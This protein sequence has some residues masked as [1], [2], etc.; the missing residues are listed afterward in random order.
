VRPGIVRPGVVKPGLVRPRRRRL[1]PGAAG[2][3]AAVAVLLAGVAA[4]AVALVAAPV[5]RDAAAEE[6]RRE[7][8][9]GIYHLDDP[10]L[11]ERVFDRVVDWLDRVVSRL[12]EQAPGG[13]VGLL[14]MVAAAVWLLWFALWRAGPLRRGGRRAVSAPVVDATLTADQHRR[15]AEQFSAEGRYADAIRERMR[16]IVRELEARGVLEPRLGRTADEVA[17]E[18]GEQVPQIGP[19]LRTAATIFDEVWYGGRPG[20]AE[21]DGTL[22]QVDGYVSHG[23]PG[24]PRGWVQNPLGGEQG[25]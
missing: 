10:S 19:A 20:T 4:R 2:A 8:S 9:K 13:A 15:R 25:G 16:A 21:A 11:L 1:R 7:L 6:A 23:M 22:R 12:S 17:A 14:V 18:A 5:Q 3:A 24:S